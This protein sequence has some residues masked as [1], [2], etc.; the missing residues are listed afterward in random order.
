MPTRRCF[1]VDEYHRMGAAGI[2]HEDER[3]ELINGEIVRMAAVGGKHIA[4]VLRLDEWFNPRL[5]GI[6]LVSVQN[7]VRLSP[8]AE[9]EPDLAVVRA[10]PERLHPYRSAHPTP[11]DVFLVVEVA[12]SSLEYDLG[13][14]ARLYAR[15]GI[16]ELWVLDQRGDR[17]VVHREPTPR[18]YA[19]VRTLTRGQSISP[20]AFPDVAFA[21]DELLG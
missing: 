13:R 18:G 3:I 21:A 1:T 5:S 7:P 10:H 8:H 17:L 12:D 19:T 11:A 6:A 2:L 20:L 15:H 9:P 16:P 14:K 4:C